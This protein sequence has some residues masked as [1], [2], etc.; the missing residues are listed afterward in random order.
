MS[1]MYVYTFY[2]PIIFESRDIATPPTSNIETCASN[3]KSLG[4]DTIR[5]MY[6]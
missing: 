5:N 6:S 3:Y 4:R 1:V 2:L